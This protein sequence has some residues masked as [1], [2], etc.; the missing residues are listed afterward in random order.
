MLH[1]EIAAYEAYMA[2]TPAERTLRETV[3]QRL[4]ASIKGRLRDARVYT[5]GSS[6]TGL[7]LPNG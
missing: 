2:S 6:A 7:S 4:V 3:T 5:Y 1:E